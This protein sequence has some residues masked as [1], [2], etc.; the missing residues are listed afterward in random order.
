MIMHNMVMEDEGEDVAATLEFE[1]MSDP[2]EHSGKNPALFHDVVQMH[3][4]I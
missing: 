2:I 4:Q 1:N 3:Q